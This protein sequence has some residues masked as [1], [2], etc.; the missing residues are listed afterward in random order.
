MGFRFRKSIKIAPGVKLNLGLGGASVS[1]GGRGASVTI[2]KR[3]TYANVGLP[4]TGLSYRTR[5]GGGGS[6]AAGDRDD[7]RPI[8]VNQSAGPDPVAVQQLEQ[9]AIAAALV[10]AIH[11]QTPAPATMRPVL[12]DAIF[13][14]PEPSPPSAPVMPAEPQRGG[15]GVVGSVLG[16]LK[17]LFDGQSAEE[18]AR[19]EEKA[20]Q[21][22]LI[23]WE[24][25]RTRLTT[26]YQAALSRWRPE[27]EQWLAR[28]AA[29]DSSQAARKAQFARELRLDAGF[30][31]DVLAGAFEALSW[32]YET[33]I[34]WEVAVE[35]TGNVVSLDIDLPEIEMLN[36]AQLT[37]GRSGIR[38]TD[39]TQKQ[40]REEYAAHIHGVLFRA[41]GVVF[42][43]L[44]DTAKVV[45]SGY[46]QRP[47]RATGFVEDEYLLSVVVENHAWSRINFDALDAINPIDALG[48]FAIQRNMT[49]TGIFKAITPHSPR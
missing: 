45:A 6:R 23:Q 48:M 35:R 34:S 38:A 8:H 36:T 24:R 2:G 18:R 4:G 28:K 27:N 41:I 16:S 9:Q 11:A 5:I 42:A 13:A 47:S 7:D 26:E 44:P 25:E 22:R 49:T 40:L 14:D 39:K 12:N 32:P 30:Q 17:G 21:Q 31:E 19:S 46:S 1:L 29:F 3:G 43:V 15:G 37:M 20:F 10:T 33:Q